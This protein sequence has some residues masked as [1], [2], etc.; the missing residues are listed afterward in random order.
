MAERKKNGNL[1]MKELICAAA[2]QVFSRNGYSKTSIR[3][4]ADAIKYS[5]GTLYLHYKDKDELLYAVRHHGFIK[6]MKKIKLGAKSLNPLKRLKQICKLYV[7]FGLESPDLYDLMFIIRAP[8]NVDSSRHKPNDEGL[9]D[10]FRKCLND[11][12]QQ[13]LLYIDNVDQ[14]YLQIWSMAHGVVALNLRCRLKVFSQDEITHQILLT[15]IDN[16]I[17]TITKIDL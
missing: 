4:I 3:N 6:L 2:V 9:T 10:Y 5:P 7:L 8:M 14:G 11:C 15:T 16:Y 13:Q 1:Q 12:I 17:D